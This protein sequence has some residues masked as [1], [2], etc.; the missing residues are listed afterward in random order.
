MAHVLLTGVTG[1]VGS[2]LARS[3]A[4]DP[5]VERV[6]L[7]VR[8]L[9]GA[10]PEERLA[11]LVTQWARFVAV[12]PP[13]LARK[14]GV[15]SHDLLDVRPPALARDIDV[16]IH[17]AASTDLFEPLGASRRA[18]LFATQ[19]CLAMARSLPKLSRFVHVSTA[20]VAGT[21][22]GIVTESQPTPNSFH[23]HYERSKAESEAAVRASDLPYVIARPSIVVGRSDDGYAPRMRVLYSVWR[24][25]L[26]GQVPRVPTDRHGWVDLVP[27]DYVCD[28]LR[29][30]AVAPE[31][32]GHTFHVCAGE[33]RQ[34]SDTIMRLAAS[35]FGVKPPPVSPPWVVPV[36]MN[37]PVR[38]F[39]PHQLLQ[40]LD[41]MSWQV[42]YLGFRDR[43]F[44]TRQADK[45]M[46]RYG[47]TRPRFAEYGQN[48][49]Q[50]C[51]DTAWGKKARRVHAAA[52]AAA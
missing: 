18:N 7:L 31:A 17:A 51:R 52:D 3:L 8:P 43:L 28:M 24:A 29:L 15:V 34:R 38:P 41:V 9:A 2:E 49:F 6:T 25:W 46:A 39:V 19:R 33:D 50:F 44:D 5:N 48:I 20:Y 10:P 13:E 32:V 36:L 12:P 4:F 30:L 42:P 14:L 47:L 11:R 16:V 35:V 27:I 21:P 26:T 23:N 37:W 45:L 22:R 1:F 40:I